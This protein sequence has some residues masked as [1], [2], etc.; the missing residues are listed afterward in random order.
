MYLFYSFEKIK[1][2]SCFS[3]IDFTGFSPFQEIALTIGVNIYFLLFLIFILSVSYKL[4]NRLYNI[5]F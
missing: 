3:A 5:I 2:F 4:V 1:A